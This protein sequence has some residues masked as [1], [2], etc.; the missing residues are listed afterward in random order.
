MYDMMI[1]DISV[2]WISGACVWYEYVQVFAVRGF[3]YFEEK[4]TARHLIKQNEI[5]YKVVYIRGKLALA[6]MTSKGYMKAPTSKPTLI[7]AQK[8][9]V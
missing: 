9:H 3:I 6:V 8:V 2:E 7:H 1:W 4:K 5:C